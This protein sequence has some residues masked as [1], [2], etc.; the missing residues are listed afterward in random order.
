MEVE[1]A[2]EPENDEGVED[3]VRARRRSSAFTARMSLVESGE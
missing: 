3:R 2:L 1:D